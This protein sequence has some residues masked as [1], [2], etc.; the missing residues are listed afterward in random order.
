MYETFYHF[1]ENPFRLTPDPAYVFMS[2]THGE[3][4]THL[5]YAVQENKGFVVI[6]GEIGAGKT[7]LMHVLMQKVPKEVVTAVLT[8]TSLL[9]IEFLRRVCDEFEIKPAGPDKASLLD[10]F[11]GY[12]LDQYAAGRR[13]VLMIDEAQ[14]LPLATL[15]EL[16]MLSNLETQKEHLIQMILLGQPDLKA[17]LRRKGLEQFVQRVTVHYHL[18]SLDREETAAYI[19]HRLH[20]AGGDNPELFTPQ[21]VHRVF[22]ASQGIPRLIN[23]LCDGALVYGYADGLSRIDE[24]TVLQ[25]IQEREGLEALPF[26]P[27]EADRSA[28]TEILERLTHLEARLER[29]GDL[30]ERQM[31]TQEAREA[32]LERRFVQKLEALLL[33]R[34]KEERTPDLE[35]FHTKLASRRNSQHDLHAERHGHEAD[36]DP[37]SKPFKR[38]PIQ[39]VLSRFR[40]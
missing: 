4:Y 32:E 35:R 6:T 31:N 37:G 3:A 27:Q 18:R 22:E 9:P 19:R 24:A 7:T 30:I 1:K 26:E 5:E 12:L 21:S 34:T 11:H 33:G 15:E 10:A 13:V 17:K 39:R 16:R 2:G 28:D 23:I 36:K 29:L 38:G 20:V 25:V 40:K 8:Q 14:N